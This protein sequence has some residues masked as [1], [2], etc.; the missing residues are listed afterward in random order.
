MSGCRNWGTEADLERTEAVYT[1]YLKSGMG[2][3]SC[4]FFVRLHIFFTVLAVA[5]RPVGSYEALHPKKFVYRELGVSRLQSECSSEQPVRV[6]PSSKSQARLTGDFEIYVSAN[7][8]ILKLSGEIFLGQAVGASCGTCE[9]RD[10]WTRCVIVPVTFGTPS[11][12][13]VY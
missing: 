13:F 12:K 1:Y 7:K 5:I 11:A 2:F 8:N 9:S 6:K 3:E 10:E 4:C